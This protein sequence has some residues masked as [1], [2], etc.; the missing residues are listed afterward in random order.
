MT[1]IL[2]LRSF[3]AGSDNLFGKSGKFLIFPAEQKFVEA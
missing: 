1:P 3:V 2:V